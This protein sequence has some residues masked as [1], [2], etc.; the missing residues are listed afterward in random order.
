LGTFLQG[1]GGRGGGGKERGGEDVIIIIIIIIIIQWFK[2]F[3]TLFENV[4][5]RVPNRNFGDF[6]VAF[7]C[8]NS[9]SARWN[10][11]ENAIGSDTDILNGNSVSF[12][13][14]LDSYTFTR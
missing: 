1:R 13:N 2:Y 12:N 5:L 8:S 11:T 14:L 7:S 9:P 6:N 3:L 4:V 10:S